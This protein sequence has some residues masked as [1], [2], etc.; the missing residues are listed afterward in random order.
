MTKNSRLKTILEDAI[1]SGEFS[2]GDRL[3]EVTLAARFGVSRTPIREALMQLGAEGLIEI[4]PR[5]GAVVSVISPH[6]LL[7]MFEAMAEI[8]AGCARLAAR[9]MTEEDEAAIRA[10]H[11]AC[12]KAAATGDHDGYYEENRVFHEAIYRASHNAFLAEQAIQLHKRLGPYR[13]LQLRAR[14]RLPTSLAEHQGVVDALM[15]GDA[16]LAAQRLRDHVVVQGER[17]SDMVMALGAA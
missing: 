15:A 4:R 14:Q 1:V 8:E 10:A 11:A 17:F 5:R 2:P 16:D 3:D 13:R 9:R 7:E 12:T 6:K